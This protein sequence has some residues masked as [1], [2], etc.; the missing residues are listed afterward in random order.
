[1]TQ[2]MT[3]VIAGK[4]GT[5]KTTLAALLLDELLYQIDTPTLA[6]DADPASTLHLVLGLPP[7]SATLAQVRE[8]TTLDTKTI[9]GLPDGM[10]PADYIATLLTEAGVI[11]QYHQDQ[12]SFH[13]LTMGQPEGAG[14]YC[15]INRAL[16][17]ALQSLL[18]TYRLII[19][20]CE[21]GLEHLSRYRLQQ[22][23]LLLV[24]ARPNQASL[25][26]GKQI[27]QT[28]AQLNMD[29]R[30]QILILNEAD[31]KNLPYLDPGYDVV[32]VIP[33]SPAL[34]A[35]EASGR[36]TIE[37]RR[38]DP[39]RQALQPLVENIIARLATKNIDDLCI[40]F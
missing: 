14:C 21:A 10:T 7:P 1:M 4:G 29:I 5:G 30:Q 40:D 38:D 16:S 37:L 34:I 15:A 39:I 18:S 20:D 17:A 3:I 36:P 12:H 23:D 2:A 32:N 8:T 26:V 24:V 6:V 9:Q 31:P 28:V 22:I 27:V 13:T 35:L 33:T 19:I 11:T 25:T